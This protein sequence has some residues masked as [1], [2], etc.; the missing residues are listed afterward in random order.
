MPEYRKI[1]DFPYSVSEEGD[2][3]NDQT[4]YVLKWFQSEHGYCRVR[5]SRN[6]EVNNFF[7]H[8]LVA[9]AFIPNPENK[10]EVNHKDGNKTNNSV[11]NLEW[12]TSSENKIHSS[13]VLGN[14]FK[15]T[16]QAQQLAAK[17]RRKAVICVDNGEVFESITSAAKFVGVSQS[18][19]SRHLLY[20]HSPCKGYQFVFVTA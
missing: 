5:L 6:K 15:I 13:R 11:S 17:A 10:R 18:T 3:R 2:V 4:G 9:S 7:V 16:P 1:P 20:L 14:K 19:L 8:R 12:V